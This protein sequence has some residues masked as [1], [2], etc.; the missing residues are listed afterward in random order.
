MDFTFQNIPI[1]AL[2]LLTGLSAGLC[3]TWSNTIT[4]GI[5][6][7]DNYGYLRA[8]QEMNRTILNPTFFMVFFGPFFLGLINLYVFRNAPSSLIW[9]LILT[10]V[11]YSFGVA[12]VTIFGNV[13]LNELLD[14][15]D[16]I[17]ACSE[18]LKTLRNTF[19]GRWNR[20]HLIRTISAVVSFSLLI[21]SLIQI[22]KSNT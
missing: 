2:T 15:T 17:T 14:K 5:G 20:L 6:N 22:T 10:T 11:I 8:F 16:L 19:E 4:T 9:L 18:D 21:I 12:L 7:L 3:F 1:I 13:P